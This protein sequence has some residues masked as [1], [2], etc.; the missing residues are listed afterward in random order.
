[1]LL[2]EGLITRKQY[3][4]AT[5]L[6]TA[7]GKT[8]G[9]HLVDSKA[10]SGSALVRFLAA[11]FPLTI[12]S[13][14][15]LLN[16]PNEV[17]D[18]VSQELVRSFR[19]LPVQKTDE[20]LTLG[21]TDPSRPHVIVEVAHHAGCKVEM[22]IVSEEEMTWAIN[23][24]YS[25]DVR[26]Q[27]T[28]EYDKPL[29]LTVKVSA[30]KQRRP[31]DSETTPLP[32]IK[33]VAS[34]YS[35]FN[36]ISAKFGNG[37]AS[38]EDAVKAIPLTKKS[39]SEKTELYDSWSRPALPVAPELPEKMVSYRQ[40]NSELRNLP[41]RADLSDKST[42]P[43]PPPVKLRDKT[44]GE[45]IRAI[46][47]AN[48]RDAVI[49]LALEHLM[50]FADRAIFM[51]VKRNEIRGFDIAG[52]FTSKDAIRAFW[53]PLSAPSTLRRVADEKQIHA[54]LLDKTASD[55]VLCAA[56]GG[57]LD[58]VVIIPIAIHGRTIGLLFADK[59]NANLPPQRKINRLGVAVAEALTKLFSKQRRP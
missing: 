23:R 43:P 21:V 52:E 25:T 15:Q 27:V 31:S 54:G 11:R 7:Y 14:K 57:N 18:V 42:L 19:V 2:A 50:R 59:L 5:Q 17:I 13:K 32:L 3:E 34:L 39:T 53:V 44:E 46:G 51:T 24:Y 48:D 56:L 4:N 10:L 35:E 45:I 47:Y 33:K 38:I 28:S 6:H 20:L 29:P 30:K 37:A 40:D 22:V 36:V 9:Y 26:E 8:I 16:I 1:M 41:F 55:L 12:C 58:K 49:G